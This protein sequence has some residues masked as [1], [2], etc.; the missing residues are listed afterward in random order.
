MVRSS[1]APA[2]STRVRLAASLFCTVLMTLGV[3]SAA[4]LSAPPHGRQAEH[5]NQADAKAK[6][7]EMLSSPSMEGLYARTYWSLKQRKQNDGFLP[8]SLTGAYPGMFPRTVGAYAL[9]MIET[10]QYEAAAQSLDCVLTA[11]RQTGYTRVPRVIGK[12]DST[13]YIEDD[14]SQIDGQA[15]LILGWARLALARGRTPFE[16][17]T[18]KQVSD[19]LSSGTD[20]PYLQYGQFPSQNGLVRNVALE[21]SREGRY[22]DTWDLLTQSFMGAALH[23]MVLV[24]KRRG[25]TEAAAVWQKRLDV[26]SGGIMKS[27]T[28]E[29]DGQETYLE[30]RLPNS[31][32][33]VPYLG[34]GWVV[35]SPLAAGW[36][37]DAHVLSNTV[38]ALERTNLKTT[39]GQVWM[40]TDGY[41]DGTFSNEIIGKGQAWELEYA[42]THE[43]WLRALQI[44]NLIG[45]VNTPSLY[46]E[47]AWLE[48]SHYH[49]SQR[50]SHSDLPRLEDT[51]WKVKDAGNAEQDT[52]F[53]WEMSR[54]RQ[55]FALPPEPPKP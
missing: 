24:A 4:L 42:R 44:L 41:A 28:T 20:R 45:T 14:E 3:G 46:M 8:E 53:C 31:A 49:L 35:L 19:L 9:L 54:L 23:D 6:V 47:G 39:H 1:P 12:R 50:L 22:W 48:D 5:V 11:L 32:A 29:R 52:W 10:R 13:Y 51:T 17:R 40:P 27:L 21:H 33:G 18:W 7:R 16:D 30:M 15:H 38:S 55:Q 36:T 34:M 43:E 37:P 2:G 26:L 25:E